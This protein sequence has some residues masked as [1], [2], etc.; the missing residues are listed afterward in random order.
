[1]NDKT[2]CEYCSTPLPLGVDKPMRQF[3]SHHFDTC[4][5]KKNCEIEILQRKWDEW[6]D[7]LTSVMEQRNQLID[8]LVE[9]R[10]LSDGRDI[11]M[12]SPPIRSLDEKRINIIDN[13]LKQWTKH[14]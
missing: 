9:L 4:L 2:M 1:M 7:S 12:G 13:A 10:K 5:V 11:Y 6:K 14:V 8:A 3:R